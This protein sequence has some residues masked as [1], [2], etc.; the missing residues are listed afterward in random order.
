MSLTRDERVTEESL[1]AEVE[2]LLRGAPAIEGISAQY[3]W[4]GRVRALTDLWDGAD[5]VHCGSHIRYLQ[6]A[7]DD[8]TGSK[9][10]HHLMTLLQTAQADLI[11]KTVGPLNVAVSEGQ[12]Y[13]Y[14][15]EIRKIVELAST[16]VFFVDPYL[17]V[18][19]V[20][21]Y[22]RYVRDGVTIRLLGSKHMKE[23]M[24]A[25][26]T[27][28]QET[29]K[30]IEVRRANRMHDRFVFINKSDCYYS[31]ASFKDGA[32]KAPAIISQIT[33]AFSAMH[34]T[35]EKM[36]DNAEPQNLPS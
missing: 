34:D 10:Y 4:L 2:D 1:L 9:Y 5:S 21:K 8:R 33:D 18:D 35:Y 31:G 24:P 32:K 36:W 7:G 23:L 17:E 12:V 30:P 29:G 22:L 11:L 25:V 26:K 16:D 6:G 28:A 14:F 3:N 27:F 15:E 19:F 13:R 20:A